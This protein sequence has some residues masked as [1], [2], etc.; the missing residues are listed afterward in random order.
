MGRNDGESKTIRSVENAFRILDELQDCQCAG[1]TELSNS[2][3]LSKGTIHHYLATLRKQG[4][5]EKQNRKYQLG[6]R[7]L[8]YGGVAREREQVF[9]IGKRSVDR[10]AETTDETAR[11]VVERNGYG[12]TLYQSTRN[13]REEVRTHIGTR[14][15][16]PSTAAGKAMLAMMDDDRIEE[17]E[18]NRKTQQGNS[19][20]DTS[21]LHTEIADVRR[22]GIAFDDEGQFDGV[23]CVAIALTTDDNTLLGAISVTGPVERI[24][25]E[26]F[27]EEMPQALRNI[28]G[29]IEIN[30]AY[31]GWME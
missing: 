28:A 13:D 24:D 3:G 14:E 15:E 27:R 9:Q 1:V 7:P 5:V 10:L 26:R 18:R 20:I 12:I 25:D 6:L 8:S 4:F 16:L 31:R 11:L 30:T 21:D 19:T 22:H 2:I 23:R 29:V 17:I